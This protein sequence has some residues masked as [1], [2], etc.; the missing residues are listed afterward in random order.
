MPTWDMSQPDA[1]S[2][3]WDL[4][5]T[6]VIT[7]TLLDI[8]SQRTAIS[9]SNP[10]D[11]A[12]EDL[13]PGRSVTDRKRLSIAM[14]DARIGRELADEMMI[15]LLKRQLENQEK[16]LQALKEGSQLVFDFDWSSCEPPMLFHPDTCE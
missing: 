14:P 1:A 16:V 12:K 10:L 9:Q 13:N 8:R 6:C 15:D 3:W 5:A 7:S 11:T 2:M 4:E